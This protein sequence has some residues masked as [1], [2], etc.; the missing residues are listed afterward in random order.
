MISMFQ[1]KLLPKRRRDWTSGVLVLVKRRGI[2]MKV[3]LLYFDMAIGLNNLQ[4]FVV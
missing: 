2:H 4:R 3:V 1:V